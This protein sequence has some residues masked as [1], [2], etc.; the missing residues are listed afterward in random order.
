M[1][2][3]KQAIEGEDTASVQVRFENGALGEKWI[4]IACITATNT[5]FD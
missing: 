5:F 3:Y 1:G 2:R 4:S